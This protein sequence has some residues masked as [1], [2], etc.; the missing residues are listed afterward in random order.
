MERGFKLG[1]GDYLVKPSTVD[2][3]V[4]KV[5]KLLDQGGQTATAGVSCESASE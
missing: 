5:K 3:L 4:A 1:A 2:V